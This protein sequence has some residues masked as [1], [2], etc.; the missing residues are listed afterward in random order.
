VR[1][2]LS[3]PVGLICVPASPAVR[4]GISTS[5]V[6]QRRRGLLRRTPGPVLEWPITRGTRLSGDVHGSKQPRIVILDDRLVL[7]SAGTML[8]REGLV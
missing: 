7:I 4:A 8:Q 2:C 5:L 6:V 1:T 3:R